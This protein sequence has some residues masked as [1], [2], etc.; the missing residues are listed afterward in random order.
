PVPGDRKIIVKLSSASVNLGDN[1]FE[2]VFR[3]KEPLGKKILIDA[4]RNN[5]NTGTDTGRYKDNLQLFTSQMRQAGYIVEENTQP[6]TSDLLQDVD[7]LYIS[8]PASQY[9]PAEIEA[10]GEFVAEG[11]G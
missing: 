11:G 4:S 7:I 5:E 1:R 9:T 6:I 3:V 10:I 2:Q 8:F